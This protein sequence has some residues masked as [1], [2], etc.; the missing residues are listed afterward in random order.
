MP[1]V[2]LV[3]PEQQ[4]IGRIVIG[5]IGAVWPL[6]AAIPQTYYATVISHGHTHGPFIVGDGFLADIESTVARIKSMAIDFLKCFKA[7]K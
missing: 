6:E 7:I 2:A 1:F 3:H 5:D 4:E